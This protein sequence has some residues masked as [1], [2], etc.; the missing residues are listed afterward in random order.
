[1]FSTDIDLLIGLAVGAAYFCP[2]IVF[3]VA[4]LWLRKRGPQERQRHPRPRSYELSEMDKSERTALDY[5]GMT[6]LAF[7][8]LAYLGVFCFILKILLERLFK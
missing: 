1:M 4:K 8:V 3:C 2:M 6:C 5:A 7:F